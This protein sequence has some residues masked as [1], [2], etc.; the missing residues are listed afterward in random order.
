MINLEEEFLK[1]C[2]E[3]DLKKVEACLTLRA[4]VNTANSF[5]PGLY[6]KKQPAA[7]GVLTFSTKHQREQRNRT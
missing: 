5:K 6:R 1:Y 2:G 3:G 7:F 4:D